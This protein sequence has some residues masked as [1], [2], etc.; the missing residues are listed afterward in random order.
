MDK[1]FWKSRRTL[2]VVAV[3]LMYYGWHVH[4]QRVQAQ[5]EIDA[6]ERMAGYGRCVENL[7]GDVIEARKNCR[8]FWFSQRLSSREENK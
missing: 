2:L 7:P 6:H 8:D 5:E 4:R 1:F 3:I